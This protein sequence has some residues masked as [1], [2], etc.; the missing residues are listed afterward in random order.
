MQEETIV[1]LLADVDSIKKLM[2]ER[3][4]LDEN[5][6]LGLRQE[7]ELAKNKVS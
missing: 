5:T 6:I 4:Q 3:T 2:T 7:I 1:S